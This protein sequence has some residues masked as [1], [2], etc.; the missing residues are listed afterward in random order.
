M[1][2]EQANAKESIPFNTSLTDTQEG[3]C[4]FL[5]KRKQAQA[6]VEG[7]LRFRDILGT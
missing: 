5:E 3:G 7:A 1:R 4:T 6:R 2:I